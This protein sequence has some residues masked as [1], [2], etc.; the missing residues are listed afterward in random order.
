[1]K[2]NGAW[3]MY[4]AYDEDSGE[5]L[6]HYQMLDPNWPIKAPVPDGPYVLELIRGNGDT[7]L[8][9]APFSVERGR[10][11]T[12]LVYGD[13]DALASEIFIDVYDD[14][15]QDAWNWMETGGYADVAEDHVKVRAL[16]ACGFYESMDVELC[17]ATGCTVAAQSI[18]Y[19]GVYEAIVPATYTELQA[20][21]SSTPRGGVSLTWSAGRSAYLV[22]LQDGPLSLEDHFFGPL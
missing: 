12:I 8:V 16:N 11:L 20:Y 4:S 1:M 10:D 15:N 9:T 13:P 6:P 7:A 21:G 2:L 5:Y 3:W 14:P 18:P 22:L 19:G 17:N